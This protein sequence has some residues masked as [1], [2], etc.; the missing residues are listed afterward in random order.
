M[1]EAMEQQRISI[2]KA[3]IT[4]TLQSRCAVLGAANPK[5]GRFDTTQYLAQQINIPVALLS[6]FDIIFTITDVPESEKDLL[7]AEHILKSHT[8]GGIE[9]YKKETG[10]EIEDKGEVPTYTEPYLDREFFRKYIAYAKRIFP[11][12]TKEASDVLRDYYTSIR[13][14]GEPEGSSVPIT[15][16]Q[17]EAFVRLS[18]ASA[19][20]RL[21]DRVTEDDARRAIRIVEYYLRKVAG[22]EGR[23]DIDIIVS[24]TSQSQRERI[25]TIRGIIKSLSTSGEPV[26]HEDIILEA[27]ASGIERSKAESIIKRLHTEGTIYEVRTGK[28]REAKV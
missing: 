15:A 20:V 11:V 18:E 26:E 6:R 17:L 5:Y 27:E 2:A 3:G 7:I 12:I 8:L 16:R 19:R 1:H 24:G 10:G 14:Q 25:K 28:Y 13:K 4:A 23:F 22:E 21:S 9:R